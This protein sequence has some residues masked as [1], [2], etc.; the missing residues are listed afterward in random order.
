MKFI[1][2]MTMNQICSSQL[3]FRGTSTRVDVALCLM[4]PVLRILI[5]FAFFSNQLFYGHTKFSDHY[6]AMH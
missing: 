5:N 1:V 2:S 3:H 6:I 4:L